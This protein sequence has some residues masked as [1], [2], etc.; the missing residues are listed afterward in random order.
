M[1][2]G[3]V[4]AAA[5]LMQQQADTQAWAMGQFT[6]H[7]ENQLQRQAG[8]QPPGLPRL[9]HQQPAP[10][11][12]PPGFPLLPPALTAA[13]APSRPQLPQQPH[14][15]S[16]E[17][18]Q[19]QQQLAQANALLPPPAGAAVTA[20]AAAAAAATA[21][22]AAAPPPVPSEADLYKAWSRAMNRLKEAKANGADEDM[23]ADLEQIIENKRAA[24]ED[25]LDQ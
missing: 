16:H 18:Q 25:A 7:M 9:L 6:S 4:G 19:Q 10:P 20:A 14:Q 22:A 5:Q 8:T 11:A 3:N 1:S 24:Y 23:I 15:Q 13:A 2:T 12:L 21:T 17:S